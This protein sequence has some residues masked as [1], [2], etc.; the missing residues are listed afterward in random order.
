MGS[1]FWHT[2]ANVCKGNFEY[3]RSEHCPPHFKIIVYKRFF[4]YLFLLYI[5][6]QQQDNVQG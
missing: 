3:I 6:I 5:N 1:P 2:L 4:G